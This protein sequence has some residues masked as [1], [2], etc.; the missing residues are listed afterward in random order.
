MNSLLRVSTAA[1]ALL[2]AVSAAS[3]QT[4]TIIERPAATIELSPA[5]RTI[6]HRHVVRERAVTLPPRVELRVGA[7]IPQTVELYPFPDEVYVEVPT[8]KRY[9]YLYV[10]NQVVLVDPETSEIVEII[11]E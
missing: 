10:N 4:T 5:Q 8:L 6:I 1:I 9:R 2:A 11:R 7:P 3:A